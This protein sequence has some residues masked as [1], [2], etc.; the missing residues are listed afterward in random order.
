MSSVWS[1]FALA[2]NIIKTVLFSVTA[3]KVVGKNSSNYLILG[4][5]RGFAISI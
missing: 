3:V 1:E 5:A 4:A 2:T